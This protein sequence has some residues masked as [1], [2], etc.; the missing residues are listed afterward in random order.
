MLEV[1]PSGQRGHT[2]T[3]NVQNGLC[4][5]DILFSC[6]MKSVRI[7]SAYRLNVSSVSF[8]VNVAVEVMCCCVACQ[9]ITQVRSE[10]KRE[11]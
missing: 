6:V 9:E 8:I 5:W 11:S 1:E 3:R 4:L 10:S 7:V 2:A